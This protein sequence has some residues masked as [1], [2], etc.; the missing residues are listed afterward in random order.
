VWS[1]SPRTSNTASP[2]TANSE[3]RAMV[4]WLARCERSPAT[5]SARPDSPAAENAA[6]EAL[7]ADRTDSDRDSN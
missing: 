6:V 3:Y 2:L 4:I 1:V 7:Y 5:A